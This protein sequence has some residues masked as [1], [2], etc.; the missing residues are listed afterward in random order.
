MRLDDDPEVAVHALAKSYIRF[1]SD[2][3]KRWS[4][5]FEHRLPDGKELPEWHREKVVRLLGLLERALAP[6]FPHGQEG[7]R[8]HSARVLWSSLHGICSLESGGKLVKTESVEAM[9]DSLISNYLVGLRTKALS[10]KH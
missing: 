7:E 4:V 10:H 3:P 8:H 9:T 1:A 5:L 6:L 2:H